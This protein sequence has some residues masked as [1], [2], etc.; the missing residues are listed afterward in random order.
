MASSCCFVL[1]LLKIRTTPAISG[2]MVIHSTRGPIAK[3][4]IHTT[5]PRC[6]CA[7]SLTASRRLYFPG[8]PAGRDLIF[9]L[10]LIVLVLKLLHAHF[11]DPGGSSWAGRTP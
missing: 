5:V 8:S 1:R 6:H 7:G 9:D 11:T 10:Q 2:S 3:F 4:S